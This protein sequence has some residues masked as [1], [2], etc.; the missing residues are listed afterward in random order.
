MICDMNDAIASVLDASKN[1]G[2]TEQL[3]TPIF[4]QYNNFYS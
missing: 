4:V 2:P 3:T 1:N